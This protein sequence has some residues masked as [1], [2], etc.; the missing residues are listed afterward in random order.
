MD[1]CHKILA[2]TFVH[3]RFSHQCELFTHLIIISDLYN[4]LLLL[5]QKMAWLLHAGVHSARFNLS[6][7]Q[8]PIL[9]IQ[10]PRP[11]DSFTT[12]H[13]FSQL[14]M[15]SIYTL[16]PPKPWR[17]H[18]I[19][20]IITLEMTPEI[21]VSNLCL[22]PVMSSSPWQ[23]VPCNTSRDSDST[24]SLTSFQCL[25]TL[26]VK[27]FFRL[28]HLSILWGSLRLSSCPVPGFLGEEVIPHLATTSFQQ[29]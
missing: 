11:Y 17:E 15:I 18:R 2:R 16:W 12:P 28:S 27:N 19:T 9:K 24:T 13:V 14:L 7:F 25:I 1:L 5:S 4:S 26:T 22:S 10:L 8:C 20:E 21:I 3:S 6:A 29:A 23:K